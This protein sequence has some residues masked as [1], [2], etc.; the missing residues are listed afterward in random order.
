M[1]EEW[2]AA[3]QGDVCVCVC[4]LGCQCVQF[5]QCTE[6]FL[7]RTTHLSPSARAQSRYGIARRPRP[8]LL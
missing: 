4:V 6:G 2:R 5:Y 3:R 1:D 8:L 7:N